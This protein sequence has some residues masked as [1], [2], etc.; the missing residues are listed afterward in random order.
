[1]KSINEKS[2]SIRSFLGAK[3]Y[4]ESRQF[5]RE[6]GYNEHII[7]AKMSYFSV[8]EGIGFYLQDYY[9]KEWCN[10]SMILL[11]IDDADECLQELKA[12]GLDKKYK[13]VRFT[14]I[15]V[16]EH[17]R[18]IFMHDPSGILWHFFEFRKG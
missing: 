5:Y 11:E 17:G 16:S 8:R 10:N 15:K 9:V 2:T 4:Q 13:H 3:N 1:M 6:M 12:L 18:E 7:D 14:D